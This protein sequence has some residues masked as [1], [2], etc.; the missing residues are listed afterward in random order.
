MLQRIQS[1]FLLLA[2]LVSLSGLFLPLWQLGT[3]TEQEV[4][5]GLAT[6]ATFEAGAEAESRYFF[7]HPEA[8]RTVLHSLV[9]GLNVVAAVW[10]VLTIFAYDD[11]PRQ[12]RRIYIG[13]VLILFQILALVFLTR[14]EPEMVLG[15]VESGMPQYGLAA[16]IVAVAL[17]WLAISRIRKDE[18]LVRS[19]DRIR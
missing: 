8:M 3:G 5:T 12:I 11:R 9:M 19:M 15:G 6:T 13:I 16:P 17:A 10:L 1:V 14:Q 4:I 18:E 7:A 2:V